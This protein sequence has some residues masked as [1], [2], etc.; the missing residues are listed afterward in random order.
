MVLGKFILEGLKKS[1][2]LLFFHFYYL[3]PLSSPINKHI[4]REIKNI[5]IYFCVQSIRIIEQKFMI[6]CVLKII[7]V[8]VY[9][10]IIKNKIV[11]HVRII[12]HKMTVVIINSVVWNIFH[13]ERSIFWIKKYYIKRKF[14]AL[15]KYNFYY[16]ILV[17]ISKV[18]QYLYQNKF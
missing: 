3:F 11:W 13:K 15:W 18:F 9:F 1:G 16:Y 2:N 4:F 12:V 5:V 8:N 17:I 7:N 14:Y 10:N 6:H